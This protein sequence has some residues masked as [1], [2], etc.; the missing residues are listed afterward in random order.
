MRN[1][2]VTTGELVEWL[3][4]NAPSEGAPVVLH[5]SDYDGEGDFVALF[6]ALA[7][8]QADN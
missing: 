5:E 7:S 1:G 2:Y 6:D 8:I 4:H 3:Q